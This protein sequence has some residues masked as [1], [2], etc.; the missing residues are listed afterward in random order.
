MSSRTVDPRLVELRAIGKS[1]LSGEQHSEYEKLSKREQRKRPRVMERVH[2]VAAN[3]TELAAAAVGAAAEASSSTDGEAAIKAARRAGVELREPLPPCR[4]D[5]AEDGQH[6]DVVNFVYLK[7][8]DGV[9]PTR[10]LAGKAPLAMPKHRT[11][12][13][14]MVRGLPSGANRG[15]RSRDLV[16]VMICSGRGGTF[17]ALRKLLHEMP[18][19]P[20]GH[21]YVLHIDQDVKRRL[22]ATYVWGPS[23]HRVTSVALSC[24][25]ATSPSDVAHAV[26][27]WMDEHGVARDSDMFVSAD[28]CCSALASMERSDRV[29]WKWVEY[30]IALALPPTVKLLTECGA[31]VLACTAVM[32]SSVV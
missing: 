25:D 29:N 21:V 16:A 7:G 13:K 11:A 8:R 4:L 18:L 17:G 10:D 9:P 28:Q 19:P 24:N 1:R 30:A 6:A 22:H 27:S 14:E 2:P 3:A 20:E 23:A 26:L 31:R 5:A 12:F 32:R 15:R